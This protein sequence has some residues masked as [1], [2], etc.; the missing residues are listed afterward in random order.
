MLSSEL[1]GPALIYL[2]F[3]LTQVIVDSF[4]GYYNTAF[5]K[6]WITIIITILLN[7][8]CARGL[9]VVSWI[10]VFIPFLTMTIVTSLLLYYF[11]LDPKT[12]KIS[13]SGDSVDNGNID[14]R[15]KQR[16]INEMSNNSKNMFSVST[17]KNRTPDVETDQYDYVR[18]YCEVHGEAPHPN[19]TC[20]VKTDE[21]FT[22]L[23]ILE[24]SLFINSSLI[25]IVQL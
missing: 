12:G 20:P 21:S 5:F 2:C 24:L 15:E 1:C 18:K 16:Q 7:S 14:V 10:I 17:D 23:E 3:S 11:G 19:V 9:G 22:S 25:F 13:I 4:K 6:M 8:L